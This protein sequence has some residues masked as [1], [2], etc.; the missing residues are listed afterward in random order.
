MSFSRIE[1]QIFCEKLVGCQ[2]GLN[3][4]SYKN[5]FEI[6]TLNSNNAQ[7]LKNSLIIDSKDLFFKGMLS[8]CEGLLGIFHKRASWATV[9]FY[10]STFYFLKS[11]LAVNSY[12]I[13]RNSSY[14]YL[15]EAIEGRKPERL[16][17]TG[18]NNDHDCVRSV[19][20]NKF[21]SKD[22]LLGNNIENISTYKW[23]MDKRNQVN[24][25]QRNFTEPLYPD[26]LD[27]L[28]DLEG[29]GLINLLVSYIKDTEH[30][31]C[32]QS[33]HA[34]IAIPIKRAQLTSSDLLKE[35][36][37]PI[38]KLQKEFLKSILCPLSSINNDILKLIESV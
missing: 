18:Y 15:L 5:Q 16:K 3:F 26:Y 29:E 14:L 8:L 32:F 13:I 37:K 22:I 31:Y 25:K 2:G 34:C 7:L 19:Y 28:K 9:K 11:S 30:I 35:I 27:K 38:E 17:G 33:E 23:L 36:N 21:K 20:E 10:Y 6:V 1:A 24:Y 4:G 12:A